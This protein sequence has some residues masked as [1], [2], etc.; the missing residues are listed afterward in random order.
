M[1]LY[2]LGILPLVGLIVFGLYWRNA[3]K[4]IKEKE[5]LARHGQTHAEWLLE[6]MKLAVK[7]DFSRLLQLNQV[8]Y[9]KT[10]FNNRFIVI[11][12]LTPFGAFVGWKT[13]KL[14][15]NLDAAGYY[16]EDLTVPI[17]DRNLDIPITPYDP[18][19][20]ELINADQMIQ[21]QA[22][23]LQAKSERE[24]ESADEAY[25]NLRDKFMK[26]EESA[27]YPLH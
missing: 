8:D 3:Y 20:Y 6:R 16:Q 14:Y 9:G 10:S 24:E 2:L 19:T 25:N 15:K 7:I 27:R 4:E 5:V 26:N 23:E 12:V 21:W 17:H 22:L 1:N 11:L 18:E 13:A